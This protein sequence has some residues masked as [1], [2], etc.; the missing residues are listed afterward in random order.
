MNA[1]G[2]NYWVNQQTENITGF[3]KSVENYSTSMR[4]TWK[5][6]TSVLAGILAISLPLSIA[7]DQSVNIPL[8]LSWTLQLLAIGV[9]LAIVKLDIDREFWENVNKFR[10][11]YDMNEMNVRRLQSPSTWQS[12]ENTG[13]MLS[14]LHE[15]TIHL[16]NTSGMWTKAATDL[17]EKYKGKRPSQLYMTEESNYKK[18][19]W[20]KLF[21]RHY[22][23][24]TNIFYGLIFL[25]LALFLVGGLMKL[26]F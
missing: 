20:L 21:D 5:H 4:E 2:Q 19:C 7:T 9:G 16:P 25:S 26:V 13:I 10:F 6:F 11:A 23:K 18:S 17:I 22:L 8:I 1:D 15:R 24:V 14:I 3:G 12:D